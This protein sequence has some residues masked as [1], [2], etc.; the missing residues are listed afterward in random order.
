MRG[1]KRGMKIIAYKKKILSQKK[2]LELA[3]RKVASGSG[4]GGDLLGIW[5]PG[6]G[7]LAHKLY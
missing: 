1:S 4:K 5:L 3:Q 2:S 6:I 7:R